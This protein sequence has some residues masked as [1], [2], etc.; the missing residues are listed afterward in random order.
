M[1]LLTPSSSDYAA[2]TDFL[3]WLGFLCCPHILRSMRRAPVPGHLVRLLDAYLPYVRSERVRF[4]VPPKFRLNPQRR[5]EL[6]LEL[7]ALLEQWTPPDIPEA[8]VKTAR[9]LMRAEGVERPPSGKWDTFQVDPVHPPEET[10]MWPE[11]IPRLREELARR[12]DSHPHQSF[13]YPAHPSMSARPPLVILGGGYTGTEAA[14]LALAGGEPSVIVTT[15]SPERAEALTRLGFD[16]RLTA[17]L[18]ADVVAALVPRGARV[19][20]TF[21]PDGETDAAIA[22]ALARA[23]AVVYLSSTAV[24]GDAAGRIDEATPV[25]PAAPRAAARLAAE[26]AYR[27][28]GGVILRAVVIYG[29]GRGLHVRLARGEHRVAGDGRSVVS[30]IHVTDL[31]RLALAALD[32]AKA[33]T[34]FVVGDNAPVPQIE[35]IAWLSARLGLPLPESAP[36]EELHDTLRHDRAIDGGRIQRALGVALRFPSYREGFAACLSSAEPEGAARTA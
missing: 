29:P 20:V 28:A 26:D 2:V 24:Y 27:A 7:R 33:G 17:A 5:E 3:N 15:R 30:R 32:R 31:A 13:A 21:P 18:S 19:L 35:V 1:K 22:P 36:R 25:D 6:A 8:L 12:G 16:A 23:R 34:V 9:A 14:R 4:L 11:G 10:L